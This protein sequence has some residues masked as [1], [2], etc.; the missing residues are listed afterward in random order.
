MNNNT[1][2]KHEAEVNANAEQQVETTAPA[3]FDEQQDSFLVTSAPQATI[4]GQP[5][6]TETPIT[7][8]QANSVDPQTGIEVEQS[9][10]AAP[11][12]ILVTSAE[13]DSTISTGTAVNQ[14]AEFATSE[15]LAAE[16]PVS[17]EQSADITNEA[18]ATANHAKVEN[19]MASDTT[20]TENNVA[21]ANSA[22]D[23]NLADPSEVAPKSATGFFATHPILPLENNLP[24]TIG[25]KVFSAMAYAPIIPLTL[26]YLLQVLFTLDARELWY[27]DEIRHA[28]AFIRYVANTNWFTLQL[29]GELYPDKPPVYFLFLFGLYKIIP[30]AWLSGYSLYFVGSAVSG[31][32]FLWSFLLFGRIVARFDGKSLLSSGIVFL[33][34]LF[35]VGLVHYARMD[36]LFATAILLSIT[37]LYVGT[38]KARSFICITLGFM[39]AALACLI[40]GGLGI[41][42]PLLSIIVFCFWRGTPFRWLKIDFLAGLLFALLILGGWAVGAVYELGSAE[43][44]VNEYIMKHTVERIVNTFHHK[45]PW[46]YY[47]VRLPILFLPWTLIL[48]CLPYQRLFTKAT[49]SRIGV[50]RMCAGEGLGFLWCVVLV[51]LVLLSALSGKI[52]IYFLPALPALALITGRALLQLSPV[53]SGIFRQSIAVFYLL[54]GIGLTIAGLMLFGVMPMPEFKGIPPW[55]LPF[56]ATIFIIST[57]L[58]T[59]A[60]VIWFVL[61]S[62]RAEGVLMVVLLFTTLLHYPLAKYIAPM[63]NFV[64]SPKEQALVIKGYMDKGYAAYTYKDYGA[65]YSFYANATIPAVADITLLNQL[66]PAKKV[67]VAMPAN[68]IGKWRNKPECFTEVHRQWIEVKE[69]IVLACPSGNETLPPAAQDASAASLDATPAMVNGTSAHVQTNSWPSFDAQT[70]ATA[71]P[72]GT[73]MQG[74]ATVTP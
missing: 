49:W 61:K 60:C 41:A 73:M 12:F 9:K 33:C 68:A 23:P 43:T 52:H 2:N 6:D 16:M 50:T 67:V 38:V 13:G 24:V 66:V 7:A 47:L 62:N 34:S 22:V 51:T 32:L 69:F 58:I 14:Q 11:N 59:G 15:P 26:F 1:P 42:I 5:L 3:S 57:L 31:L 64:L 25:A 17:F 53:S 72:N 56:N 55:Q 63:F 37:L 10:E 35:I 8:P 28:D 27:S 70:N 46:H 36:L 20:D 74:N 45:E 21:S 19:A 48:F 40:K 54:A 18:R 30:P 39:L 29:N 65:T 4:E 44:F 71:Q